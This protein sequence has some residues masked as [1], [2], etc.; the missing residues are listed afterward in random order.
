MTRQCIMGRRFATIEELS[1]ETTV[2]HNHS[3]AQQRGVD[4]QFNI[5]DARIKL[6][7]IYPKLEV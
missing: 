1:E 5:D 4:W 6:K 3:N 2:W 7:S